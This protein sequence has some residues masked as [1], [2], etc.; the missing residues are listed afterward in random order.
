MNPAENTFCLAA[1]SH[2]II[3]SFIVHLQALDK[4][5]KDPDYHMTP[6]AMHF[7]NV[8]TPAAPTVVPGVW[9]VNVFVLLI[10]NKLAEAYGSSARGKHVR[11]GH[12]KRSEFE[13]G[14][15]GS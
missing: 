4:R 15:C 7:V 1:W 13:V 6:S 8:T 5:K 2:M 3:P 14:G 9:D 12:H 10:G 11:S